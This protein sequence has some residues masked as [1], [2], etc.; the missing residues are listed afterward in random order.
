[1]VLPFKERFFGIAELEASPEEVNSVAP[2]GASNEEGG[3]VGSGGVAARISD[4]F[5]V[6]FSLGV[7]PAEEAVTCS[8][9]PLMALMRGGEGGGQEA[10]GPGGSHQHVKGF[11]MG[12]NRVKVY[13]TREKVT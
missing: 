3:L 1:M 8:S 2:S 12:R 6:S 11:G 7:L 10:L 13:N 4:S 5:N 9:S